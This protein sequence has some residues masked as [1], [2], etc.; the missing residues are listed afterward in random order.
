MEIVSSLVAGRFDPA[1][2]IVHLSPIREW[3]VPERGLF[4]L[5]ASSQ[6]ELHTRS[7]VSLRAS[8]GVVSK[9]NRSLIS[10]QL[11]V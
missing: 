3:A 10:D 9:H 11:R 6:T 8:C 5:L 7:L 4:P 1:G 2:R